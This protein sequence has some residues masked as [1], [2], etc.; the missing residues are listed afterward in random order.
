MDFPSVRRFLSA[1]ALPKQ[2]HYNVIDILQNNSL[3]CDFWWKKKT[4][5]N[6]FDNSLTWSFF[7]TRHRTK[8]SIKTQSE[9]YKAQVNVGDCQGPE[10]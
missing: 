5:P 1:N 10:R 3:C 4:K 2:K 6:Y 8:L 9:Q 7:T